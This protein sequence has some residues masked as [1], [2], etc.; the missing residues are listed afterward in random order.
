MKPEMRADIPVV[1]ASW[2]ELLDKISILEIK[3]ARIVDAKAVANVRHELALL[4]ECTQPIRS[5]ASFTE[6]TTALRTVNER[7]WDIEDK[8]RQKERDQ[9]FDEEFIALARAVYLTNDERSAIKRAI[10][11]AIGS[12]IVEE[13]QHI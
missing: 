5:H 9:A 8:I 6:W 4:S 11:M 7:L 3:S 1:P 12:E 10:N 2:G 13:K